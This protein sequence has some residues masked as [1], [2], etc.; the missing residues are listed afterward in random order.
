MNVI[1]NET[2]IRDEIKRLDQKTGL[3]G[4][5]IPI[6]FGNAKHTL[7]S[8]CTQNGNAKQ[9][10]FS[11]YYFQNKDFP[12]EEAVD[13]IRHEYAHYMDFVINGKLGHSTS[14]K[15]CCI[16]IGALPTRLYSETRANYHRLKHEKDRQAEYKLEQFSL[17]TVIDHPRFGRGVILA[18]T[19]DG[20]SRVLQVEFSEYGQ[21]MLGASWVL[22]NC[23]TQSVDKER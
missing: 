21:K 6:V 18:V 17:G 22:S 23:K 15:Q 12:V 19:G 14:W 13:T 20:V 7:G 10:R 3:R 16:R 2:R 11:N 9:F 5:D 8:F 4:E 1:W